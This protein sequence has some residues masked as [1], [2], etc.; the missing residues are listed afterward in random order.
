MIWGVAVKCS[1]D[2][3][4]TIVI[5]QYQWYTA[6]GDLCQSVKSFHKIGVQI[7]RRHCFC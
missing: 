4:D 3:R 7:K 1:S 5:H 2:T 6:E